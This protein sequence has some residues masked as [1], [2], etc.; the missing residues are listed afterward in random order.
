MEIP[1]DI[2]Q[3]VHRNFDKADVADALRILEN[4]VLH[5]GRSPDH[6]MLRCALFASNNSLKSLE[7]YVAG[8]AIDYRD[9]ILAGEYVPRKGEHVRL[10]DLSTPFKFYET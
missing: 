4:A 7:W 8:L 9:V 3:Y 6:R 10:R 2:A 1:S 5:D